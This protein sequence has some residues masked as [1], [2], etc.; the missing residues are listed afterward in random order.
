VAEWKTIE[1]L[2]NIEKGSLQSSKNIPGEYPFITAA[3]SWK[4]HSS[5]EHDCEALVFAMAASGSLGRTH[6]VNGRFISSDLCFVLTPKKGMKL[7]LLFYYRLFN[8]L[9]Q[10]IVKK[11]ATGTSKL[12]IN[13]TNF[14]GY[15]LPYFDYDYQLVFRDK[16]EN[17]ATISD[18][19]VQGIDIQLN[20]I[21]KLRQ[22]VLQEAIE[23]KLT[24]EWRREHPELINGDNHASKLLEKTKSGK[25]R[26]VK[27]GKLKR[28]KPLPTITDDEKPF[29]LPEGW[30][31][32]YWVDLLSF[33]KHSMK[34]GPFGS[35]L[36]KDIF[37]KE[38]IRVF[39]QYNAINDD[40]YWARYYITEEKFEELESFSAR[41][42][43]LLISCSGVTLGRITEIPHGAEIGIINQALLKLRLHGEI[44]TNAYFKLLFRSIY[45]QKNIFGMAWGI[46]IPNMIG[47]NELKRILIP[48]PPFKEQEAIVQRM[49]ELV[50]MINELEKQ[51]SER[52]KQC[53][54]LAQSVLRE[55]FAAN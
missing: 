12:S 41:P 32:C 46:A 55:A 47:V 52:K 17:L 37:V 10:D 36:R 2:F 26:S 40:P 8:F 50:A 16:I 15:K 21:D 53:E 54:M 19:F 24:E 25:E 51:V 33:D 42:G 6:Y 44:M 38:G 39:E 31:W 35:A 43:D 9:R 45:M 34:R 22:Q 13:R 48:L 29:E 1:E 30:I 28:E 18:G 14:N 49:E 3:E 4:T 20:L 27:E 11:T 23:G 7:D 5:Y